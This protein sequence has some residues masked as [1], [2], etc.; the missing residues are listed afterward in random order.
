[1][2]DPE[3]LRSVQIWKCEDIA[4]NAS[5]STMLD[6]LSGYFNSIW[7]STIYVTKVDYDASDVE[8]ADSSL[9]A[10]SIYTV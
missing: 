10:K 8:T 9:I 2:W 6:S 5:A 1:L 4:D 7:G 3:D